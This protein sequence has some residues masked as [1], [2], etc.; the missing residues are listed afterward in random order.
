MTYAIKSLLSL[1]YPCTNP[2]CVNGYA[3]KG[4]PF[5]RNG[6][7]FIQCPVCNG[8]GNLLDEKG[9][10]VKILAVLSKDQ[11]LPDD[12]MIT[13]PYVKTLISQGWKKTGEVK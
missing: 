2:G 7:D 8:T 6:V 11:R 13:I 1:C 5:N 3:V 12:L 10:P 9:N 4:K